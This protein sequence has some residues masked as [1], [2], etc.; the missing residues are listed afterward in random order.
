[1]KY[2]KALDHLALALNELTRSKPNP[3]LAA[4]LLAKAASM[5]DANRALAIIEASNCQAFERQQASRLQVAKTRSSRARVSA[6]DE[7]EAEFPINKYDEVDA[8][9]DDDPVTEVDDE[10]FEKEE[11]EF[12]ARTMASVLKRMVRK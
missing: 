9:F 3:T 10:D 6:A 7:E 12:P 5:P 11:G 2:N 4:R 8:E 1:M